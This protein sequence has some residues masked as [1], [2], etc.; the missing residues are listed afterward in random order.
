MR[1]KFLKIIF[2]FLFF[3]LLM[4]KVI[5]LVLTLLLCTAAWFFWS[6]RPVD[7]TSNVRAAVK[8]EQGMSVRGIAQLLHE[9][10]IVRSQL[11]FVLFVRLQGN[12]GDLQAGT[13]IL[14]PSMGV[15]ELIQI[16]QNGKAKELLLTIPEGFTV[17]EIDALLAALDIIESGDIVACAQTCDFSSFEFLPD[18]EGFAQR[19]GK[20]EG[21]LFPDTY[22]IE[23]ENFV[24]KFFLERL[25][26][27]FR[28]RIREALAEEIDA[29]EYSLNEIITMASL[30]EEETLTEEERPIVSGILWKRYDDGRGLGVDA[31][32]RYLTDNS[33]DAITT[34]DLNINS[35]YNTRKFKGLPP[36]PIASPGYESVLAALRPQESE[37]WYYLHGNDGVIHYAVTNE[38]HNINRWKFIRGVE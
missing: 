19:G 4:K 32:V 38:E 9:K 33:S 37:Y 25:L 18:P 23:V 21:Y 22:Y 27:T 6:L 2:H 29:S 13:F 26:T 5:L 15:G 30:I 34:A 36:G 20:L 28:H 10:G 17:L 14:R 3:H 35:P 24:P 1:H 11:A 31:T 8:V 7:S 16:L 12:E